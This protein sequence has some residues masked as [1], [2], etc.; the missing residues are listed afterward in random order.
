MLS[1]GPSPSPLTLTAWTQ[2]HPDPGLRGNLN[3][4]EGMA[5]AHSNLLRDPQR[6]RRG[7]G[8]EAGGCERPH[9]VWCCWNVLCGG[10]TP[11]PR[12]LHRGAQNLRMWDVSPHMAKG[13]LRV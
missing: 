10:T 4:A 2:G 1:S 5:L 9:R 7:A 13:T 8:G 11:L 12:G 6:R 3:A